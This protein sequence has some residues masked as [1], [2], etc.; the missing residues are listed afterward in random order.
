MQ[1][2]ATAIWHK[3]PQCNAAG[4]AEWCL[5]GVTI[6]KWP[7][8]DLTSSQWISSIFGVIYPEECWLQNSWD[9]TSQPRAYIYIYTYIY[10]YFFLKW[11]GGSMALQYMKLI[12]QHPL[13]TL[14][15]W[16]VVSIRCVFRIT[17]FCTKNPSISCLGTLPISFR[18]SLHQ[19][20]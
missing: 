14:C 4:V 11:A 5:V 18:V 6:H 8:N 3:R 7:L 9:N 13:L 15:V 17:W 19:D 16:L 2:L 12:M 20:R 1:R 10:I